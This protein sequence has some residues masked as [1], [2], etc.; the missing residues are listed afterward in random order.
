MA[1]V[2]IYTKESCAYCFR[3]KSLLD[4]RGVS[5]R[6]IDLEEDPA[7]EEEMIRLSSGRT[8]VPQIFINGIHIGGSDEL[9]GLETSGRLDE[10]LNE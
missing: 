1:E 3:V 2:V 4:A 8:E 6:E 10:L 9:G 5:Y 7:R